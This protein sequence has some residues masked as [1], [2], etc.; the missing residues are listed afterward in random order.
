MADLFNERFHAFLGCESDGDPSDVF[1]A[2]ST[3]LFGRLDGRL[4][5]GQQTQHGD[6]L[7]VRVPRRQRGGHRDRQ[8]AQVNY[9]DGPT[10]GLAYHQSAE[11][12][13]L[14]ARCCNLHL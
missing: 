8:N 3:V 9:R 14:V 6:V 7:T 10:D 12:H 1:D 2:A 13:G 4:A 11:V 5:G